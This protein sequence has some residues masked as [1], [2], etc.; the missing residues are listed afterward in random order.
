MKIGILTLPLHTN[1][2]GLLQAY[3]LQKYLTDIG[4]DVKILDADKHPNIRPWYIR[5]AIW[6]YHLIQ[7]Y[8][9]HQEVEVFAE[10]SMIKHY[11]EY[12]ESS[13]N[14]QRFIDKYLH[15]RIYKKLTEINKDEFDAIVVGSDQVWRIKYYF[16]AN[17]KDAYLH[18]TKGWNIKRIAYAASFGTDKWEYNEQQTRECIEAI[19]QFDFISVREDS[20]VEL[21]KRYLNVN[22][23]HVV[24]PTMLLLRTDYEKLINNSNAEAHQG[25]LLVYLIDENKE[26]ETLLKKIVESYSLTPFKVNSR[27]ENKN[28]SLEERIQPSVESWLRGF[29]DAKFVLTDSFHACIFSIIFRKPFVVIGNKSRG[30]GRF[31]SL[32]KL[33]DLQDHLVLSSQDFNPDNSYEIPHTVSDKLDYLRKQSIELINSNL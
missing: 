16:G 3:A 29:R 26:N 31:Y 12:M 13:K 17:I 22:A 1:Y 33:F 4:H 7:R 28:A 27:V 19:Q 14:T 18:F 9:L 24:D 5:P 32:L 21:C 23:V 8:V 20:G 15:T 30:L 2:G 6:G 25:N 10:R 11:K